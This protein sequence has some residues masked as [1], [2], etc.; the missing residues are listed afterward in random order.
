M[1][2]RTLT[3]SVTTCIACA[4]L[5]APPATAQVRHDAPG[6]WDAFAATHRA[7]LD[8]AGVIGA[9]IAFVRDGDVVA[10]DYYGMADL[11][12]GRPVDAGT[13]FHWA[14]VTKT[15]TAVALMQLRD[16]GLLGLDDRAV[17]TVPELGAVHDRFGPVD[18][19]TLRMLLSHSAGFRDPTWPWGGGEDWHPFE[20]TEWSQLVAMMP[21]TEI[22]FEPGSRY[23]YSNPGL[24]FIGRTIE[25][26]AG[27]V[28]EAY[29]DKNIFDALGMETAYFDLTPWR[30]RERRSNSYEVW[31]GEPVALGREFNTGITVS[32]GGLN[33]T[34]GDM[35]RWV[36]FLAGA[37]E[38]R[39]GA[40]AR[41]DTVLARTSLEEMWRPVVAVEDGGAL[42]HVDMGRSFFLYDADGRRVVGH[43]GSQHSFRSF[44]LVDPENHTGLIGVY[45][46]AGGDGETGVD[47]DAIVERTMARALDEL[48]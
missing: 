29:I 42:G 35:A 45:N 1:I 4:V 3:T 40:R 17:E 18:A 14:S 6:A 30:L 31:E 22:L 36:A 15:F 41:Y 11:A 32:N 48:F 10:A 13:I 23:S 28:Y 27:D 12:T 26:R 8:S 24:I 9:T 39:T 20:P 34:V 16:H 43:T 2:E 5:A 38:G 44:I 47:T 37:P 21:Y 33:A 7:E 25:T 46:T 19:I